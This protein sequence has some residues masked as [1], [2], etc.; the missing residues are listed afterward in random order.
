MAEPL[1][2]EQLAE[3]ER[4]TWDE[5]LEMYDRL[6]NA[7]EDVS[8]LVV[9]VRRLRVRDAAVRA[10]IDEAETEATAGVAEYEPSRLLRYELADRL[11]AVDQERGR[12]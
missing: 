8:A 9:E 12:G 2:D 4:R 7:R 3:I 10:F 11:H 6:A 5:D 1:T